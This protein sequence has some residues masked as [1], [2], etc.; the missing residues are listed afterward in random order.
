MKSLDKK[1]LILISVLIVIA[2][3]VIVVSQSVEE[4]KNRFGVVETSSAVSTSA[5][6]T[7]TQNPTSNVTTTTESTTLTTAPETTTEPVTE[8]ITELQSETT[9]GTPVSTSTEPETETTTVP[10]SEPERENERERVKPT[11]R[12][13]LKEPLE[14]E[15]GTLNIKSNG[16]FEF[17]TK[18]GDAR[19]DGVISKLYTGNY[20]FTETDVTKRKLKK[21]GFNLEEQDINNLYYIELRIETHTFE[22]DG[23][24][25]TSYYEPSVFREDGNKV[26][27]LVY[28]DHNTTTFKIYDFN[29]DLA[30]M[31]NTTGFYF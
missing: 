8:P 24:T 27:L 26:K 9:T 11:V 21:A 22:K 13:K 31:N 30:K 1:T 20:I 14:S 29:G 2:V 19:Y 28:Y 4:R 5:E 23:K 3:L 17:V 10:T 16:N 6:T 7:A 15:F 12:K 18:N 25:T